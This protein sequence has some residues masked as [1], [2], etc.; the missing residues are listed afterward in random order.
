[1]QGKFHEANQAYWI[2]TD[3]DFICNMIFQASLFENCIDLQSSSL[4]FKEYQILNPIIDNVLNSNSGIADLIDQGLDLNGN[5]DFQQYF[6][7]EQNIRSLETV[8]KKYRETQNNF[9]LG[10]IL[11]AYRIFAIASFL[12]SVNILTRG[13]FHRSIN[14]INEYSVVL[15]I[16]IYL[17]DNMLPKIKNKQEIKFLRCTKFGFIIIYWLSM[18]MSGV[19]H[20]QFPPPPLRDSPNPQNYSDNIID[21]LDL[22]SITNVTVIKNMTTNMLDGDSIPVTQNPFNGNNKPKS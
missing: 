21:K 7:R 17:F 1:M 16:L 15:P 6:Q 2:G 3:Y 5:H 4:N 9:Q 10:C 12:L 22:N 11:G 8:Y 20:Q 13:E 14:S 19:I 18:I